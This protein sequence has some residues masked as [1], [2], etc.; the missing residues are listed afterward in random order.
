M[1]DRGGPE[2]AASSEASDAVNKAPV[3][4]DADDSAGVQYFSVKLA[5]G[6]DVA[7]L[8]NFSAHVESGR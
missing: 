2:E 5:V 8:R 6:V 1:S 7:P 3:N 4:L